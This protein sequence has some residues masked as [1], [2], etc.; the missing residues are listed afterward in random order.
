MKWRVV[1]ELVGRDG[2]VVV[3]EIGGRA[4][5]AKYVPQDDGLMLADESRCWQGL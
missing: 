1:M 5:V 2:I 4:A 3:H